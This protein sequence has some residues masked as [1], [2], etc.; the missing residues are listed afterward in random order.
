[1]QDSSTKKENKSTLVLK[2]QEDI[3]V[4][5]DQYYISRTIDNLIINA[6]Q[7]CKD[8][9]IVINLSADDKKV[10]FSVSDNGIGIPDNE[11]IDIFGAFTVSSR[12]RTPAGGRGLGLALC[13]KVIDLHKGIITAENNKKNKGITFTFSLAK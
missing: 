10:A 11:L 6:I 7:Y 13:K 12:T 4:Q 9:E 2:V 5:C 3:T 8:G 1:M